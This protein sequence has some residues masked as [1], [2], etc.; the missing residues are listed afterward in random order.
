MW[1]VILIMKKEWFITTEWITKRLQFQKQVN[2]G[3]N[4][5]DGLLHNLARKKYRV[6]G[7][8]YHSKREIK[9][10]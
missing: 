6:P 1:N 3:L 10:T 8:V 9:V 7:I 4:F 5:E 2:S